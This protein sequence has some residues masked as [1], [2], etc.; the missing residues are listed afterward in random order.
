MKRLITRIWYP[1]QSIQENREVVMRK[2]SYQTPFHIDQYAWWPTVD[3]TGKPLRLWGRVAVAR[4]TG[5]RVWFLV[6]G[7]YMTVWCSISE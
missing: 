7:V 2:Q 1:T 6:G 3:N 4:S 5:Y